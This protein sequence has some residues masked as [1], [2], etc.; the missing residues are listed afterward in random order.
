LLALIRNQPGVS[1]S[2]GGVLAVEENAAS[3]QKTLDQVKILLQIM[4]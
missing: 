2:P 4:N 3:G 1:F